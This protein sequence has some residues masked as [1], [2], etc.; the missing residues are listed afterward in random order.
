MKQYL[1][2]INTKNAYSIEILRM[3]FLLVTA[4]KET[5]IQIDH[6]INIG[7]LLWPTWESLLS[8]TCLRATHVRESFLEII[9][10]PVSFSKPPIRNMIEVPI[11]VEASQSPI[12]R[13]SKLFLFQHSGQPGPES[14]IVDPLYFKIEQRLE[15]TRTDSPDRIPGTQRR[16]TN[17]RNSQ[18]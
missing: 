11:F 16:R 14:M 13:L 2:N 15:R 5:E 9:W 18:T 12:H 10:T 7:L 8:V 3:N 4:C 1:R 17:F 6:V